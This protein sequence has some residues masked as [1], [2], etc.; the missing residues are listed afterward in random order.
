MCVEVLQVRHGRDPAVRTTETQAAIEALA[1]RGYL[2][3]A[4]AEML[5]DG[6]AFLRRLRWRM[7]ILHPSAS[8]LIEESAP[9]LV[10]LARRMGMRSRRGSEDTAA[11]CARYKAITDRIRA[12]YEEIVVGEQAA[13]R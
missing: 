4:Q 9:G 11:L 3:A 13:E 7:R 6:Y 2:T 10:P 1:D 8:Q 5:R 12:T